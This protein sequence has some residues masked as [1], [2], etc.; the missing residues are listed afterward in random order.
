MHQSRGEEAAPSGGH[1]NR[2]NAL[3]NML[4]N[5]YHHVT[6]EKSMLHLTASVN[7]RL[8]LIYAKHRILDTVFS[9]KYLHPG[10]Q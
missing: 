6:D 9:T 5:R 1:M 3:T 4:H 7:N 10:D 2:A 8:S